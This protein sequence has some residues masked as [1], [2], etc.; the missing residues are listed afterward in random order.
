MKNII[1]YMMITIFGIFMTFHP[2]MAAE[3]VKVIEL[4]ESGEFIEFPMTAEE[5]AA[6]DAEIA[7]R[8]AVRN[9]RAKAPQERLERIELAESGD[10]FEFPM[11]AAE[12]AAED[13]EN[14]RRA[15]MREKHANPGKKPVVVFELA[16]SGHM[17]EFAVPSEGIA[18]PSTEMAS[19]DPDKN[20]VGLR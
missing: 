13:E 20:E 10:V 15:A 12:I 16:E 7:R 6:E 8:A 9:A 11:S 2:A 17:I 19:S 14:A 1:A 5:I 4:A 18:V 3:R